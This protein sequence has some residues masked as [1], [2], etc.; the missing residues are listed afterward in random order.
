VVV[1]VVGWGVVDTLEKAVMGGICEHR[2]DDAVCAGEVVGDGE[3]GGQT[4]QPSAAVRRVAF[5][6]E[7]QPIIR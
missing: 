5:F 4:V 1:A 3:S 6:F 7:E 2:L